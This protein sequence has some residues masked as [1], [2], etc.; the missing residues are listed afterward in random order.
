M[1]IVG[2][3]EAELCCQTDTRRSTLQS[4]TIAETNRAR[5]RKMIRTVGVVVLIAA[6]GVAVSFGYQYLE[7][8]RVGLVGAAREALIQSAVVNCKQR[9]GTMR[10]PTTLTALCKCYADRL[11][12][13]LSHNDVIAIGTLDP[14]VSMPM[15][16]KIDAAAK[17][18]GDRFNK[19]GHF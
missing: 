13:T 1:A 8:Q 10:D 5:P 7:D 16:P 9:Q 19:T 12:D 4:T 17:F 2:P 14:R 15:Q 18:C 3:S 11:A 6:L